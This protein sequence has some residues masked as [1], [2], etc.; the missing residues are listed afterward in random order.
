MNTPIHKSIRLNV[1]A[2]Q[3]LEVVPEDQRESWQ[4]DH[5]T[6]RQYTVHR[7]GTPVG[8]LKKI[9]W[10]GFGYGSGIR[11]TWRWHFEV[12][13]RLRRRWPQGENWE[14]MSD[15][16]WLDGTEYNTLKEAK[17]ALRIR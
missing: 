1:K 6:A 9:R 2:H 13:D 10:Q 8:T 17:Q 11:T 3:T 14:P 16:Q 15:L 4:N 5:P 12:A 7:Y